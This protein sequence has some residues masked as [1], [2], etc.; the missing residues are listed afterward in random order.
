MGDAASKQRMTEA[1]Y[2]A[3]ERASEEKHEFADG[4][5]VATSGGTLEHSAVAANL[6]RDLGVALVGRPC[7]PLTS[8]M[9]IR[10]RSGRSFYP[11]GSVV[12]GRPTFHDDARDLLTN[13]TVVIEVLSDSS[14]AY[15][16]GEKFDHY[17]TIPELREYVLASQK[18]PRIEVFTRQGDDAWVRRVYGPGQR[19]VLAAIAGAVT[20]PSAKAMRAAVPLRRAFSSAVRTAQGSM[21]AARTC[22]APACAAAIARIPEPVPRSRTRRKPARLRRAASSEI[23]ARQPRVVAWVPLPNA[24]PAAR[25]IVHAPGGGIV[26]SAGSTTKKRPGRCGGKWRRF[27]ASQSTGGNGSIVMSG[28][29][30]PARPATSVSAMATSESGGSRWDS[31]VTRQARDAS[32]V[33]SLTPASSNEEIEKA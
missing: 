30:M 20:L 19:A 28:T 5:I 29:S 21:S 7:R 8:D 22:R 9:R 6:L 32:G 15:D 4:E 10:T 3:F 13:P 25:R 2:L 23:A 18:A 31:A 17:E 1:E 26:T 16:R 12:C 14:E 27:S 11:D 33:F 24:G